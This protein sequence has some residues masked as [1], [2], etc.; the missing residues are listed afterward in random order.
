MQNLVN[1]GFFTRNQDGQY[2]SSRHQPQSLGFQKQNQINQPTLDKRVEDFQEGVLDLKS[3]DVNYITLST[4]VNFKIMGKSIDPNTGLIHFKISRFSKERQEFL[5]NVIIVDSE[6]YYL[7]N[8]EQSSLDIVKATY[9]LHGEKISKLTPAGQKF[10]NPNLF[11]NFWSQ[12]NQPNAKIQV[13]S[14][15]WFSLIHSRTE[16]HNGKQAYFLTMQNIKCE[17]DNI[18]REYT[19]KGFEICIGSREFSPFDIVRIVPTHI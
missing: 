3:V 13:R 8:K 7:P 6:G 9:S 16:V 14:G 17:Q 5:Y 10:V 15:H 4:G 11:E 19:S 2:P 18:E 1:Q 12:V